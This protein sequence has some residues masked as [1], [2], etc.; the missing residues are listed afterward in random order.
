MVRGTLR[1]GRNNTHVTFRAY[2]A[3]YKELDVLATSVVST[4]SEGFTPCRH[5]RA[6]SRGE[7]TL[8]FSP[9]MMIN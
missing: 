9:V 3:L 2:R 5:L 8:L 4:K 6:S 1:Y 7:H